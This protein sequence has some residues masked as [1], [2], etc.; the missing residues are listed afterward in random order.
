MR[1]PHA[2]YSKYRR[3]FWLPASNY[4]MLSAATSIGIFFLVW[5]ILRD[6]G[7]GEDT[8]YI[9]AGLSAS[10]VLG[11]AVILR[12]VILRS[13]R[14]RFIISQRL[15]DRSLQQVPLRHAAPADAPKLTLEKNATILREIS[16]KSDAAKVLGRLAE[17]HREVFVLCEEY[18]TATARELPTVGV[19]SPRIA[20]L[21]RG[22]EIVS[23]YH[24]Y[25]LLQWAEIQSRTL[26][27]DAQKHVKLNEKLGAAQ[28]ALGVI[29]FALKYY[30]HDASLRGSEELLQQFISSMQVSSLLE[31]AERAK[32]K[33]NNKRAVSLY[34]DALFEISR[35]SAGDINSAAEMIKQEI[36]KLRSLPDKS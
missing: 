13:A 30:P 1:K 28:Q 35:A 8:S 34:K 3:P 23:E 32:F 10:I 24:H 25:H 7:G 27:Q 16:R 6:G 12:E 29:E 11:S 2:Q 9:P 26:T 21:R 15:L 22:K 4:Y 36:E 5:G 17:S 19:G 20:A 14:N 18:L 31:K 33:G